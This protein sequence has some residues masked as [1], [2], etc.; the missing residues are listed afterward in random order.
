MP[1]GAFQVVVARR[2][3]VAPGPERTS[4]WR[5]ALVAGAMLAALTCL[6]SPWLAQLFRLPSALSVV[7]LGLSLLPLTLTGACQGF[8][9]A[10]SGCAPWP[11]CTS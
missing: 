1:A 6:A 5:T 7:L 8:C 10:R 4:G 11:A 3:S 2:M 9:W